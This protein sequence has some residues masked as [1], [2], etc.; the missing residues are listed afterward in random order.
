MADRL[1][2]QLGNYRLVRLLG[3]GGFAD[4]YLGEHIHLNSQ[5]AI[6][7]LQM[8][9]VGSALEQF[10]NEGRAIASLVHPNIVRVF[11]FGVDDGTP[12]LVMDYAP[13]GTLRQHYPK[14]TVLSP[15][16]VLP[17]FMQIARA[18]QYAHDRKLMHRDIKPEN[19]LLGPNNEVLLSDFGL[20]L[21]A[22]STGS[23]TVKEMAGTLPYMAPEQ[24]NGRPRFASDQYALGI[25][26]YEWLSGE[27]PF[28]GSVVEIA[29]QHMMTPPP[30]LYGRVPGISRA[31]EEV[32]FVAL[33]KD[34]L[35]RF[36][37]I[38]TF[39]MALEQTCQ[40][41]QTDSRVLPTVISSQASSSRL[42]YSS[43]PPHFSQQSPTSEATFIKPAASL[44]Q[45]STLM[46]TPQNQLAP[47]TPPISET[48]QSTYI[49]LPTTGQPA[50]PVSIVTP[51]ANTPGI[52]RIT[53]PTGHSEPP[54]SLERMPDQYH[55][56]A[57][58][59]STTTYP[60]R[61]SRTGVV[62]ASVLIVALALILISGAILFLPKTPSR[63]QGGNNSTP[64][65]GNTASNAGT[66]TRVSTSVI[67]PTHSANG[68][69]PTNPTP[70]V[71]SI[72]TIIPT[73]PVTIT[74]PAITDFAGIWY[75]VDPNTRSWVRVEIS[76]QGNTLTAHFFGACTPT[77]CDAGS[78]S[79]TYAGSPV[80]MTLTESFDV[81]KFTLILNGNIL[82][83]T[84]FT[85][86][87]D[88]SGRSDYTSQDDFG[89]TPPTPTITDFVG[90]WQNVDPNT[91]DWIRVEIT[92]QGNTLTAHF[93]GACTPTPCDAGSTSTTYAGSP[94]SMTLVE[95]FATR[96]FTLTL[97][98]S[99]LHITTFTHFTDNSGRPDYTIQ[100][101]FHL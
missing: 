25:V 76:A 75:N 72:P 15:T 35:K 80:S 101:D 47:V 60:A 51:P 40:R 42:T 38:E 57:A 44:T 31:V 27:R 45:Q 26:L 92:A 43:S 68:S 63:I 61:R 95:S 39:A 62:F 66:A 37:R 86:F 3:Q 24:I 18:L 53:T 79:T 78:T 29:T 85:H 46:A 8:R 96:T 100:D 90:V 52:A 65:Q 20:A 56:S 10:R 48:A 1:R 89:T 21:P 91:R 9:L 71:T 33:A 69:S 67:T 17:H 97:N 94:V 22:Q 59:G 82:H 49:V 54:L 2:Q 74:G 87:T 13:N 77:P 7:V 5:A 6:K 34:P 84:S 73:T 83:V 32:L 14:G 81:M 55:H 64:T 36:D 28:H 12:F 50:Q 4:V 88:N 41:S 98:G 23:Q 70:T 99:I 11:D 16:A 93:F 30:P 58:P 19:M